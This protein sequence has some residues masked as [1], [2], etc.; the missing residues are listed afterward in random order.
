M[1]P[2]RDRARGCWP[3]ILRSIGIDAK[4]LKKGAPCPLCGGTDRFWF[5]DT[6]GD[7]TWFCRGCGKGSGVDLVMRLCGLEFRDAAKLIEKYISAEPIAEPVINPTN[8]SPEP[9]TKLHRMWA[10]SKPVVRGDAVDAYLRTRGVGLD[11][12]PSTIRT[13]PSLHYFDDDTTGFFPAMLALVHDVT[14]KPVTIHRTYIAKDGSGKAP[15]EKPRKTVSKHGKSPHIQV[16]PIMPTMGIAEGIETALA[17]MKIFSVPTWSVISTYGVETFEPPAGVE[18][19]IIFG[20]HDANGAGQKAAHTLAA[21]LAGHLP[22]EVRIPDQV[23][24]WNDVLRTVR[25]EA[26]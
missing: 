11:V 26:A 20:D 8:P 9:Q 21:G 14:G 10:K 15:V 7:G 16:T 25:K 6:N 4:H 12:Y 23:G 13:A 19:L 22:V 5:Y 1:T 24:D 18:R 2:L 3:H 17:A